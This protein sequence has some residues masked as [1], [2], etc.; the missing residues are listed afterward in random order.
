VKVTFS[1][2][3]GQQVLRTLDGMSDRARNA[4]P[5][6]REIRAAWL[7]SNAQTFTTLGRTRWPALH[8]TT[9]RAKARKGGNPAMVN[10]G[11]L[12]DSLTKVGK[13]P[14]NQLSRSGMRIGTADRIALFHHR[15]RGVP[16]RPLVMLESDFEREALRLLRRHLTGRG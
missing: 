12:R 6:W 10:T 14:I 3:G 5:V 15:G 7:R 16:R 13:L 4:T 8:P 9:Q 1:M 2:T 11:A